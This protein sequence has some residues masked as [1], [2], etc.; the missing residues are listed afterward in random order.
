MAYFDTNI[1]DNL[2]HWVTLY[3]VIYLLILKY[4]PHAAHS[5]Y[6]YDVKAENPIISA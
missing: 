2:F 1:D 5:K 4:A 3:L 6:R